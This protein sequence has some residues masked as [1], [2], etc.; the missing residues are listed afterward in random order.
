MVRTPTTEHST[1]GSS[2]VADVLWDLLAQIVCT[3][4]HHEMPP[5]LCECVSGTTWVLLL[6]G[7]PYWCTPPHSTSTCEVRCGTTS[8]H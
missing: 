6:V 3:D 8:R 2:A 4:S 5:H 1:D 7:A